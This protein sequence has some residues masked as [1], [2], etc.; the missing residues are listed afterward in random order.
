MSDLESVRRARDASITKVAGEKIR[1]L[2]RLGG[3]QDSNGGLL[4]AFAEVFARMSESKIAAP[5]DEPTELSEGSLNSSCSRSESETQSGN[6]DGRQQ[7]GTLKP[8]DLSAE[9]MELSSIPVAEIAA[10]EVVTPQQVENVESLVDIAGETD[11]STAIGPVR[12]NVEM[13]HPEIAEDQVRQVLPREDGWDVISRQRKEKPTSHSKVSDVKPLQSGQVGQ[14]VAAENSEPEIVSADIEEE[15]EPFQEKA[16]AETRRNRRARQYAGRHFDQ[17]QRQES[18]SSSREAASRGD[19]IMTPEMLEISSSPERLNPLGQRQGQPAAVAVNRS[20]QAAVV[21]TSLTS[22]SGASPSPLGA[23]TENGVSEALQ[24]PS[25]GATAKAITSRPSSEMRGKRVD[26]ADTLARVKLIQRVSK[27]FQ[28]LGPD[29]GLIRLR[30]APAEMGS[31][32]VEMRIQQRKVAARVVAETEAASAALREHLPDLRL[33]LES[34]GMQVEQLEI[35]TE[36]L[37]Q[38]TGSHF[39][40]TTSRDDSWQEPEQGQKREGAKQLE[41]KMVVDVSQNVSSAVTT[42]SLLDGIDV[43]L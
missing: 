32:R 2:V 12:L 9:D 28:H 43:H 8:D 39:E 3:D 24:N 13:E 6:D 26:K 19:S 23:K 18:Y 15:L 14:V 1:S 11:M 36:S 17:T 25:M 7:C 20:L 22:K 34:F 33:R 5:I 21:A 35:E 31:V 40:D 4:D 42:A 29:G 27:A 38:E 16:G 41:A 30:L 10:W 37:D